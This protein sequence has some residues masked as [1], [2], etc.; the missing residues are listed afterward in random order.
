[1]VILSRALS[2]YT[3][4]VLK[5]VP[6]KPKPIKAYIPVA[7]P[8]AVAAASAAAQKLTSQ[9]ILIISATAGGGGVAEMFKSE[10][11]V[12]RGLKL[13]VTWKIIQPPA[14]F[15][16]T[17]KQIH[18]GLQGESVGITAAQW[19]LYEQ[20]NREL[21]SEIDPEQWDLIVVHD[22]QP[23]AIRSYFPRRTRARW[24]WRCHIDLSAPDPAI[25]KRMLPFL[26]PYDG[27]I[28]SMKQ[29]QLRG[30]RPAH[31]AIIPP[32]IDPLAPKNLPMTP[33]E[34]ARIVKGYGINPGVPLISQVS[35]FDR[36]KDP[37]GVI[38]AWKRA[39][40]QVPNLQLAL[41]GNTVN[42]DPESVE[43]LAEVRRAA[44]NE[45]GIFIIENIPPRQ[46]DR[47][48]K[49]FYAA[50]DVV[51]Q[52]SVREGFGLT[53]SEA[54][55][56]G[57]PVVAGKVG[58]IVLQIEPGK[59]GY[60]ASTV[61]G[62]ADAIVRLLE[63]PKLAARLGAAGHNYVGKHFLLPRLIEDEMRFFASILKV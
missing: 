60:L 32:V 55:W 24:A 61:D 49:A 16:E 37:V 8:E 30:L 25:A 27:L 2:S 54:L 59:T 57:T 46:N 1:M 34:A 10:L 44:E 19:Q 5:T 20:V 52:K 12:L 35:R 6:I 9:K 58:G 22:P 18:N 11:P 50:S 17:T 45:T 40:Q 53:V 26:M 7:G 14:G 63:D 38:E 62:A 42:D 43:V 39:R 36:W 41:V 21:A 51:L 47:H 3:K 4:A 48:V 56:A 28:Y 31:T 15:F 23:A 13:N 29:Y 33:T